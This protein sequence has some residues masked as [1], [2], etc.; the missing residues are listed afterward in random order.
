MANSKFTE[1]LSLQNENAELR[2]ALKQA[3]GAEARA[4]RKS[5]GIIEAVYSAAK[6][7]CLAVGKGKAAPVTKDTRKGRGEVALLHATDWQLG[8]KTVSYGMTTCAERMNMLV[9]KDNVGF[10]VR[11]W[12]YAVIVD[13]GTIEKWFIEEGIEHNCETDPYGETSPETIL[14]YLQGSN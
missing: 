10:G 6:D 8:K 3:Q 5:E 1:V 11:S 4:K 7:S 13:N 2:K 14:A 12:R 9:Q